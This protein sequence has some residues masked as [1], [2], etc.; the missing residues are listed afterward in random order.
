MLLIILTGTCAIAGNGVRLRN[1]ELYFDL[2]LAVD[3]QPRI[4][5]MYVPTTEHKANRSTLLLAQPHGRF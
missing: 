1:L 3:L 4:C 2:P 5:M